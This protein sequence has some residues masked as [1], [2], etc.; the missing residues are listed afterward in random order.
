MTSTDKI[1]KKILLRAPRNRVWMALADSTQ[2]GT[3]F[4]MTLDGP[5]KPGAR[6]RGVITP[7]NVDP[8]VGKM[9]KSHEG[10]AFEMVI[11]KME[12]EK[13]FSFRWRSVDPKVDDSQEP[14]TLVAFT[15]EEASGGVM[16][17]VTHS[18]FDRIPLERRAKAFADNDGG[19]SLIVKVLEKYVTHAA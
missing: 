6:M 14:A 3:W 15:L 10:A 11:E 16:L 18:G 2:F 7:T 13:L 1:E 4:G 19:W 9:Q 12:S 5:F 8:E 17:T